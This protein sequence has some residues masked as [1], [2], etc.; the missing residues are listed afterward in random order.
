MEKKKAKLVTHFFIAQSFNSME[1]QLK[2]KLNYL[3]K[4]KNM[5]TVILFLLFWGTTILF[6]IV[7]A[8]FYILTNSTQGS[9]FFCCLLHRVIV[10]IFLNFFTLS[11]HLLLSLFLILATLIG[12]RWSLTVVWTCIPLM[13]SDAGHLFMCII[14]VF[15]F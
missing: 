8:T 11:Q 6:S 5:Q 12:A 10:T 3:S 1:K 2:M 15:N 7:V 9:N 14:T 4:R 13:I